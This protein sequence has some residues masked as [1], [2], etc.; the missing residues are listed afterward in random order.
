MMTQTLS[1][2]GRRLI[3]HFEGLRLSPYYDGVGYPTIG[4]GHLLS[5]EKWADLSQWPVISKEQADDL[6]K[7]DVS[8]F[9]A[10]VARLIEVPLSQGQFDALVSFSFNL[11]SGALQTSTLRRVLNRGHYHEVPDQF[12]RWV[13]AGGQ[14]LYGLARRREAEVTIGRPWQSP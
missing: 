13:F 1:D 12:R 8:R 3:Q 4:C 14:R 5:R 11:G 9:E 7:E 2:K 10:A 6:L